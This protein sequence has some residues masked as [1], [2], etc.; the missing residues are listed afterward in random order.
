MSG[1]GG[2]V[3]GVDKVRQRLVE[4]RD[5][6]QAR[7][8]QQARQAAR[9]AARVLQGAAAARTGT[10]RTRV[11][12]TED[13]AVVSASSNIPISRARVD[14]AVKAGTAKLGGLS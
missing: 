1:W 8:K 5:E 10:V 3:R 4:E 12:E 13:G 14:A 9:S 11:V 2:Q 6:A 7:A